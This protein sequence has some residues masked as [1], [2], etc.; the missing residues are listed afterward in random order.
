MS[1]IKINQTNNLKIIISEILGEESDEE[2]SGDESGSG[3]DEEEDE[4]SKGKFMQ[5]KRCSFPFFFLCKLLKIY[6]FIFNL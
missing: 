5:I 2:G 1:L 3:D 4:E 6:N